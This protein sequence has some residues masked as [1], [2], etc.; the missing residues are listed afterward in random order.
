MSNK[1]SVA[2]EGR[3]NGEP[4]RRSI[5]KKP[6]SKK[7]LAKKAVLK[8][9]S[10]PTDETDSQTI[11]RV[12]SPGRPRSRVARRLD[13]EP[14][15]PGMDGKVDPAR[16]GARPFVGSTGAERSRKKNYDGAS[17]DE[18]SIS[19]AKTSRLRALLFGTP[20]EVLAR[21]SAGDPLGV[22]F[23]VAEYL[24]RSH[25]LIDADRLHLRGLAHCA[26]RALQL[27]GSDGLDAF[28]KA[29]VFDAGME[30]LREDR[31]A[32]R[33]GSA[34]RGNL[35]Q[36]ARP[37]GLDPARVRSACARFNEADAV[38]RAA[39]FALL[40]RDEDIDELAN[41]EG[42]TVTEIAKRARRALEVALVALGTETEARLGSSRSG[43]R[44][45]TVAREST[46]K[47]A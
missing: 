31:E 41:R 38:D 43:I 16:S 21:I 25:Q 36:I 17:G 12:S 6:V 18:S 5:S 46:R 40:I 7:S 10:L 2:S 47:D 32:L 29:R 30:L 8:Q 23:F 15:L 24:H 20:R 4:V 11:S 33:N 42:V 9:A 44:R 14:C 28:I 22:R 1:E 35:E 27:R 26:R 3:F 45:K 37:L 13:Q 39:A 19:G 34:S